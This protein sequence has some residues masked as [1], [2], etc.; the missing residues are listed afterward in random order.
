MYIHVSKEYSLGWF[1]EMRYWNTID[2]CRLTKHDEMNDFFNLNQIVQH[3]RSS[4]TNKSEN[5]L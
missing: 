4:Y 3:E 1:S 5:C 2:K